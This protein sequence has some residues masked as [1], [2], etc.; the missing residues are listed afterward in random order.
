MTMFSVVCY[1]NNVAAKSDKNKHM[2]CMSFLTSQLRSYTTEGGAGRDFVQEN[3]V[4]FSSN[5]GLSFIYMVIIQF[6]GVVFYI[7]I[8]F[9]A[10]NFLKN[11]FIY[12]LL[13]SI[14]WALL[15]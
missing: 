14:F 10:Y 8:T 1:C 15:F 9:K 11:S 12:C 7:G 2:W 3:S 6:A 13:G 4:Y 5:K